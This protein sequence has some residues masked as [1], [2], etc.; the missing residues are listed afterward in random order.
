MAKRVS[1]G[2]VEVRPGRSWVPGPIG[3][4]GH[5]EDVGFH[6]E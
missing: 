5:P 3:P 2:V 6:S 1:R 4:V